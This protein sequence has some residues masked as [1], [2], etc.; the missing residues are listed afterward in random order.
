MMFGEKLLRA[1]FVPENE[2]F[3]VEL[4][5][6]GRERRWRASGVV[7][8]VV[9]VEEEVEMEGAAEGRAVPG[10]GEDAEVGVVDGG[11]EVGVAGDGRRYRGWVVGSR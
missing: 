3:D 9:V 7:G 8:R 10:E 1:L 6:G 5:R 2:R 11:G 4:E